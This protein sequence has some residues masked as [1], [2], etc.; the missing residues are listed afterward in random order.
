MEEAGLI[1]APAVNDNELHYPD[2]I[3][4]DEERTT[5]A[6][7]YRANPSAHLYT[8]A[9]EPILIQLVRHVTNANR[10]S[11]EVQ[12]A[13]DPKLLI[14]LSRAQRD[15]SAAIASL[16]TKLR[17]AASAIADHRGNLLPKPDKKKPWEWP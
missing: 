13:R 3:Q 8:E 16:S 17:L 14:Q 6:R 1:P 7:I 10:I 15:E 9:S 11:R 12:R 5:F 2:A 4:T